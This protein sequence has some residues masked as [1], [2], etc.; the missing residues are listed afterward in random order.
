MSRR[1]HQHI[2]A[3]CRTIDRRSTTEA[4]AVR[5]DD[6]NHALHQRLTLYL[7]ISCQ[8]NQLHQH[9]QH[10]QQTG[11]V[12]WTPSVCPGKA[13]FA[14]FIFICCLWTGSTFNSISMG[15][16]IFFNWWQVDNIQPFKHLLFMLH[17]TENHSRFFF[18][19]VGRER[20]QFWIFV[21]AVREGGRGAVRKEIVCTVFFWSI[22]Y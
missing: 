7:A 3:S 1:R 12:D 6:I 10:Y 2:I 20:N 4:G 13:I 16:R 21:T 11:I 15:L 18:F 8:F 22:W 5:V 17:S 14:R 19:F 9:Y